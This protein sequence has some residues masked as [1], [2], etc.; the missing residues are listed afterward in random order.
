[1]GGML[2]ILY[3]FLVG[4]LVITAL[5]LT[6]L[7]VCGWDDEDPSDAMWADFDGTER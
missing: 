2:S 7:A 1:M 6:V 5:V 4:W 3:W